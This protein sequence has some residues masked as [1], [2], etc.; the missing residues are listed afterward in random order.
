MITSIELYLVT[1]NNG[2]EAVEF[3][4]DVFNAELISC[5]TFGQAIPDTPEENKNLVLNADLRINGIRLQLSD[6]GSGN[7][8]QLGTNMT[9]C[10]QLDD[11]DQAQS[12]F[13]KLEKDAKRIDMPM[14]EIPWS[15]AYGIVVDKFG[16]TW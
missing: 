4:K 8:Y 14:Q 10:I 1:E 12:L 11:V 3:Y 15:P 6:N 2:L 13:A 7:P 16:M 5:T 9:A